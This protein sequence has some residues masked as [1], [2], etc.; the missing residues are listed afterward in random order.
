LCSVCHLVSFCYVQSSSQYICCVTCMVL[1][2]V[3]LYSALQI[4]VPKCVVMCLCCTALLTVLSTVLHPSMSSVS[5]LPSSFLVLRVWLLLSL[6]TKIKLRN[7]C[8]LSE[9]VFWLTARFVWVPGLVSVTLRNIGR[10]CVRTGCWGRYFGLRGRKRQGTE[11]NCVIRSFMICTAH[12]ILCGSSVQGRDGRDKWHAW[13]VL[14][15]KPERE[16]VL[17]RDNIKMHFLKNKMEIRVL[18]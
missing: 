1:A 2:V 14:M 12:K 6:N 7:I 8:Y 9:Q 10:G 16:T 5:Y 17:W 11:E 18:D 13:R 3:W 15:G 4:P